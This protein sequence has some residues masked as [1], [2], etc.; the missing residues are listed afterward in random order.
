M[1]DNQTAPA[2]SDSPPENYQG[3]FSRFN[4]S[5]EPQTQQPPAQ[6]QPDEYFAEPAAQPQQPPQAAP[7]P[8][9]SATPQPVVI[10]N[11][12]D[13]IQPEA[14]EILM[15]W[16]APNRPFKKRSGRYFTTT[17]LFIALLAIILLFIGQFFFMAVILSAG[18]LIY[19][20]ATVPPSDVFYQVTTHGI[21]IDKQLFY[22]EDLGRFWNDS[23]Y[24][25][26][27]IYIETFDFPGRITLLFDPQHENFLMNALANALINERPLPT[28]YDRVGEMLDKIFPMEDEKST[29]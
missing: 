9:A 10:E 5:S 18:F 22:W 24:G 15:A 12:L 19:V 28:F 13:S 2:T 11:Q 25:Q 8:Q 23:K 27:V 14:E 26:R 16:T 29:N 7:A 21:R 6:R 20:T 17:T 1:F 3:G 4:R